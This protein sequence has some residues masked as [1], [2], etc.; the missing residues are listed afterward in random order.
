MPIPDLTPYVDLRFF[1]KDPQDV[2]DS[3]LLD[4]KTRLPDWVPRE[5]NVEVV[6]L[7]SMALQVAEAIFAV[8][9]LPA[10]VLMAL[11]RL[12][13]IDAD[14]GAQPTVML[15][16]EVADTLGHDIP[17]G[18]GARLD[19]PGGLEP[20]MF[21]TV[22]A[23]A[24]P[25]GST[26]GQ[27]LA[28]GDRFTDEANGTAV[29][30]GLELADSIYFVE[31]VTTSTPIADGLE[32]ETDEVWIERAVQRLSRLTETLVMPKHFEA[33]ALENPA[34]Q[35]AKAV[36]N[37]DGSSATPGSL[38]GHVTVAIYGQGTAVDPLVA[39]AVQSALEALSAVNL[40]VHI[41]SPVVTPVNVT[42]S[43][44]A[45]AGYS[46]QAT[47]DSVT[48]ALQEFLS[49]ETWSWSGTVRRNEL[50]SVISN[51]P[52]VDYVVNLSV[53]AVDQVLPGAANL[54]TAGNLVVTV[55]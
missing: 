8:N 36:D 34:V 27:V 3:A 38:G 28:V 55:A 24:I 33:A 52:G 45:T 32:P 22:D 6:L 42:V 49:T 41:I 16:I 19:L 39:G 7:E 12:Y 4:L 25:I 15:T 46:P 37:W 31:R 14:E 29:G 17:E 30:T 47:I 18:T 35:R 50:L 10:A 53:P 11:F 48:A 20:V 51:A 40:V 23:L 21:T 9:R 44:A 54:A 43:V 1:D 5:G 13:G 2:F 26:S